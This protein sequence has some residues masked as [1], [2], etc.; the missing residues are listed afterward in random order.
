MPAAWLSGIL[1]AGLTIGP[2]PVFH[3]KNGVHAILIDLLVRHLGHR[4]EQFSLLLSRT[5][6]FVLVR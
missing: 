5:L 1:L 4:T 6:K 2:D 3:G